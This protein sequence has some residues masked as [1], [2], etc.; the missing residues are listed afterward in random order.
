[1]PSNT[2]LLLAVLLSI[3]VLFGFHYLYEKPRL[4]RWQAQQ[5]LLNE[6]AATQPALAAQGDVAAPAPTRP[7]AE[8]L[9]ESP[10]LKIN[11]LVLHGSLPLKGGRIDDLTLVNYRE[12]V[13]A[14][15][16]EIVLLSPAGSALPQAPYYAEFGWLSGTPGLSVPDEETRWQSDR[17][18]LSPSAPITFRWNNGA[19]VSFERV[20]DVDAGFMFTVT[21]RAVNNTASPITLYPYGLISRHTTPHTQGL[22][23]LHEGPLGVKDGTLEEMKYDDLRKTP[24]QDWTGNVG[25]LGFTDKYWLVSLIP[26]ASIDGARFAYAEGGGVPRY[27]AD[28][29][30]APVLLQ[31]GASV[32]VAYR[33]FAGAKQVKLIDHYADSLKIPAFDRAVDFGWFYFL[34]KPFFFALDFLGNL[35]GNFGIGILVFTVLLKLLFFPLANKS[36]ES[37]SKLKLLQPEMMKLRERFEKDPMRMQQEMMDLYKREKV[38]PMSGCL[39]M[40]IQ[41]PFFFA[42]YKVLFV[43]IEMRHAPFF[44]WVQDLS[45]PDPSN[46]FTLF[47]LIPWD[48]PSFLL[49]GVWPI[50]MGVTMWLQQKLQP[51]PPDKMQQQVFL[52]LPVIFTFLL[53]H[54][55]VGLVIYWAWSNLLSIAQQW[56]IMRRMGVKDKLAVVKKA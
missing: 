9:Q 42:L 36:Y 47:G 31:P 21:Q 38:N 26:T 19:G 2:N 16:P 48:P 49:L 39:P 55:A 8:I 40:V 56:L 35:F 24:A 43:N 4:E 41:I 12:T 3:G 27:Q 45:A 53:A 28:I 25:W 14:K 23:I 30:G 54:M 20:V 34:T 29:K 17:A 11:T 13:D 18:I 5:A 32:E 52:L 10:R 37:M 51:A 46:L 50:V 44:G 1:M 15:S 6:K 7:R 33:L 22:F